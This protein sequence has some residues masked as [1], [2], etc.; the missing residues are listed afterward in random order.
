MPV[1]CH[2]SSCGATYQVGQQFVGRKIK[3]PKCAAAIL[4]A[5]AAEP[6]GQAA[7]VEDR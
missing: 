2:C 1:T 5:A 3:C 6:R 7:A 4:V